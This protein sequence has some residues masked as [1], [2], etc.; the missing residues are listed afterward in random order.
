MP[1]T[2]WTVADA[3]D[4]VDGLLAEL[5][6]TG[7]IIAVDLPGWQAIPAAG[8]RAHVYTRRR[9]TA[10]RTFAGLTGVEQRCITIETACESTLAVKLGEHRTGMIAASAWL[11]RCPGALEA[12]VAALKP[13]GVLVIVGHTER[14]AIDIATLTD[15]HI[16][17]LD[18]TAYLVATTRNTFDAAVAIPAGT[19]VDA[20]TTPASHWGVGVWRQTEKGGGARG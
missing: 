14:D 10:T 9:G 7:R 19:E 13:G 16:L 1:L 15:T 20:A 17:P 12:T 3:A 2:V 11:L 18:F 5:A 4:L 8:R 6:P